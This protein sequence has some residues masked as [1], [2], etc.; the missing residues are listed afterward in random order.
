MTIYCP[1]LA[2]DRNTSNLDYF[3]IIRELHHM[4]KP[5]RVQSSNHEFVQL[6]IFR[7]ETSVCVIIIR[8]VDGGIMKACPGGFRL[9]CSRDG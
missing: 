4:Q 1:T 6:R 9:S 3:I 8:T 7:R 5:E 2:L